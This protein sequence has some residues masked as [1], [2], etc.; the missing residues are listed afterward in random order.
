MAVV[1]AVYSFATPGWKAPN[2]A[3]A[4]R[5]RERRRHR[6]AHLGRRD[7]GRRRLRRG[8]RVEDQQVDATEVV[9]RRVVLADHLHRQH[10]LALRE[11]E[12]AERDRFG[13]R[14]R[15][16]VEVDRR[17]DLAAVDQQLHDA[18]V[19]AL[20]ERGGQAVG[21]GVLDL[22]RERRAAAVAVVVVELRVGLAR[23]RRRRCATRGG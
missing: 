12:R 2:A 20:D 19:R 11:R 4:E 22:E 8:L 18:E 13:A 3:G 7:R 10:V 14:Q 15:G 17:A 16:G 1:A 21:V 9:G 6:A 5:Q 23:G